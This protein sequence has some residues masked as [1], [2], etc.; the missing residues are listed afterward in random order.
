MK[1]QLVLITLLFTTLCSFA[2]T[3]GIL[4]FTIKNAV[5]NA[6]VTNA[7]LVNISNGESHF[8]DKKGMIKCNVKTATFNYKIVADGYKVLESFTKIVPN[9]S[10]NVPI[11]LTPLNDAVNQA[12]GPAETYFELNGFITD[13]NGQPLKNV[14]I[15][16]AYD[17]TV[18]KSNAKGFYTYTSKAPVKTAVAKDA[19]KL[20]TTI[21]YNLKGHKLLV[22]KNIL[23]L[24]TATRYTVTLIKGAGTI[25]N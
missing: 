5:T 24:P 16:V 25:E 6:E 15:T 3:K 9:Q 19:P 10:L 14:L 11:V 22:K 17:N 20:T 13:A 2:Q 21:S 8:A 1:K 23:V 7:K 18:V 12:Q 4:I